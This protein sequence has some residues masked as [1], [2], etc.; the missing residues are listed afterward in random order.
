MKDVVL[1]WVLKGI[2]DLMG[3][4]DD[5]GRAF[6]KERTDQPKQ[7]HGVQ[8]VHGMF[9]GYKYPIGARMWDI[10]GSHWRQMVVIRWPRKLGPDHADHQLQTKEFIQQC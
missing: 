4:E 2:A 5:G 8:K 3:R 6:Q 9:R 1:R 10:L 7:R